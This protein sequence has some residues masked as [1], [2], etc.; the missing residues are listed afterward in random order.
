MPKTNCWEFKECGREPGGAKVSTL[1]VC[2]AANNSQL[3]SVHG[4]KGGGRACWVLAG[5][6]CGGAV[7]GTFAQKYSNCSKCN[8]YHEVLEQEG[9]AFAGSTVLLAMLS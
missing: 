6:F 2:P 4:G 9:D 8:F 7:Q 1:G 5:T 3:D